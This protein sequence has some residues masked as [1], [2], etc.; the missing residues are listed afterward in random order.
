MLKMDTVCLNVRNVRI[1]AHSIP[2]LA[3]S[4]PKNI[5]K[6]RTTARNCLVRCVCYLAVMQ[7]CVD[8]RSKPVDDG[9]TSVKSQLETLVRRET[10]GDQ[11]YRRL[12]SDGRHCRDIGARL[13]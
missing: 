4:A 11:I 8:Q 2:V 7:R 6:A 13:R 9:L 12:R 1:A 3:D 5:A 10:A